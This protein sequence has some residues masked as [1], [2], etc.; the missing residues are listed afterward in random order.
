MDMYSKI[1]DYVL[2][3]YDIYIC[4]H[5]Y[6]RPIT[7]TSIGITDPIEDVSRLRT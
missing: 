4:I 5:V 2:I 3:V 1:N 7:N 6:N